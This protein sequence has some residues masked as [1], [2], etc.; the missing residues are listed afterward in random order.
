ML[1]LHRMVSGNS[2]VG[3]WSKET[4]LWLSTTICFVAI[5]QCNLF[6]RQSPCSWSMPMHSN[7]INEGRFSKHAKQPPDVKR[8]L[9]LE[10]AE[11]SRFFGSS[12]ILSAYLSA[13]GSLCHGSLDSSG[14]T[15]WSAAPTG[16]GLKWPVLWS[17]EVNDVFHVKDAILLMS[18]TSATLRVQCRTEFFAHGFAIIWQLLAEH[19]WHTFYGNELPGSNFSS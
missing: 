18:L 17:T 9:F 4:C 14:P 6:Y 12:A 13:L 7:M 15:P 11:A 19:L 5:E 3:W 1:T 8:D 2:R 16:T 10:V